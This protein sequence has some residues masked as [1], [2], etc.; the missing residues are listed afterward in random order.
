MDFLSRFSVYSTLPKIIDSNKTLLVQAWTNSSH[1]VCI[2]FQCSTWAT[3]SCRSHGPK[4]C[5]LCEILIGV[6][7][8]CIKISLQSY[9]SKSFK[10]L[11]LQQNHSD[12]GISVSAFLQKLGKVE[13]RTKFWALIKYEMGQSIQEW[14]KQNFWKIAFN[15]IEGVWSA[16]R[17]N[18]K[19][20]ILQS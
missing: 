4:F 1:F 13:W 10:H 12:V 17:R 7:N 14:T 2:F 19:S 6:C 5:F 15:K 16:L 9:F 8:I 3:N 11:W 18:I 20:Q